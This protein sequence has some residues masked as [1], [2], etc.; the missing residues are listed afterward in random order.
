MEIEIHN[1]NNIDFGKIEIIED[2]L[3][4]KY[5]INGTGKSTLAKAVYK[6]VHD[7]MS[8]SNELVELTPFKG[9]GDASI[10][11]NI[12]GCEPITKVKIFD[13]NYI[14]EFVYQPDE[15]LKGSFDILIRDENYEKVMNDIEEL[16]SEIKTHFSDD[17]D[18][19]NLTN[20]FNELSASFGKPTKSGIHGASALAKA[21]KDGNKINNIPEGLEI[22]QDFIQGDDN[23]KWVKW[24]L[25]GNQFVDISDN[26]PYCVSDVAQVKETI[27][28]VSEVYDSKSIQNLN[29]IIAVFQRLENYFSDET[30]AIINEFINLIDGYNDEQIGFLKEVKEQVDRLNTKFSELKGIGFISFKDVDT[31]IEKL[32]LDLVK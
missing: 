16:V 30:K 24:Q 18:I 1:C 15:L 3:N 20:D 22:Y 7:R 27:K 32:K 26:C 23:V 11:P 12:K 28:K 31:V 17:S 19:E 14:N 13:E 9:I 10:T 4:I 6:S 2:K 25:D 29:K 8:G 21:F 5:A